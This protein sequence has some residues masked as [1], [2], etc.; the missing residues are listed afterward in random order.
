MIREILEI[1]TPFLLAALGGLF[2]E[3]AGILNIALEGIMLSGA[4]A[5]VLGTYLSGSIAIG[6]LAALAAGLVVAL[7]FSGFALWLRANIFIVGL[8]LNLM[9][10]GVTAFISVSIFGT[11]GVISFQESVRL[12]RLRMPQIQEIPLIGQIL[13]GHTVLTYSAWAAVLMSVIVVYRTP[14][15]VGLR[16]AGYAP[17]TLRLRGKSPDLFRLSALAISGVM[18][19][20]GGAAL[21]L[22][23]GGYVPNMSAG[24]GWIALVAIY[25]GRRRPV[26]VLIACVVFA[27]SE[28]LAN[29]AQ[30]WF[31]VPRTLTLA[32]PYLI[33]LAGMIGFG[34]A[35]NHR[36]VS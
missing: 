20:A 26:G 30:G 21:S 33:T 4:F 22:G 3:L 13:S 18:A 17:E 28:Y 10:G 25:L 27:S 12:L 16:A 19:A 29:A 36:G 23:L 31:N 8:A 24:R 35:H 32:L 11:K 6:I 7:V 34:V 9:A 15:G 2:A 5:A 1:A 14:F